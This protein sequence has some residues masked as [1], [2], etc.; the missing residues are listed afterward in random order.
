MAC[1]T[2]GVALP[3]PAVAPPSSDAGKGL[4]KDAFRKALLDELREDPDLYSRAGGK[5]AET[6]R[7]TAFYRKAA[8]VFV[9][10]HPLLDQTCLNILSDRKLLVLPSPQLQTGFY[11]LSAASIPVPQRRMALHRLGGRN[12]LAPKID[13]KRGPE[14]KIELLL[15][16]PLAAGLD[17]SMLGD[18]KGHFD[19]QYALLYTLKWLRSDATVAAILANERFLR[20]SPTDANDILAHQVVLPGRSIRTAHQSTQEIEIIWTKLNDKQVRRNDAL[21]FLQKN[22]KSFQ[23]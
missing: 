19:L 13:Y 9:S 20:P 16:A 21:F 12:S 8:C 18:G 15:T 1:N 11:G 10:P 5:L 23:Q 22:R 17:G 6:L 4:D 2:T 7:R 3:K 14:K